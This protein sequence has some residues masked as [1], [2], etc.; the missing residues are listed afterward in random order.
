M[1]QSV[2]NVAFYRFLSISSFDP[3]DV[4]WCH[5]TLLNVSDL[6]Y[7]QCGLLDIESNIYFLFLFS[8][9]R[10]RTAA[11]RNLSPTP[12]SSSQGP[13]P[14]VSVSPGPPKDTSAPGGPPERTVTPALSS[15]VLP[16]RLGSPATSVPG[17]GKQST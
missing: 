1:L 8:E 6:L 16:R 15:N 2:F 3:T 4:F 5:K 10:Q 11:Q 17:M 7:W 14:Q 13:P 12:A 9:I